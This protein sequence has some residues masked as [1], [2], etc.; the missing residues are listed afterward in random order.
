MLVGFGWAKAV[1]VDPARFRVKNQAFGMFLVAIAGASANLCIALMVLM[2][3]FATATVVSVMTGA[4]PFDVFWFLVPRDPQADLQG[5]VAAFTSYM[6]TANLLLGLFNLLPLPPLDGFQALMSLYFLMRGSLKPGAPQPT[7][8]HPV[9]PTAEAQESTAAPAK[10]HLQ[11]ALQYHKD[12]QID[13]AIARYRQ[14]L[15]HD[16]GLALAYYN[17]G[18]AYW[19]KGRFPLAASAFKAA[20]RPGADPT[21]RSLAALRLRELAQAEREPTAPLGHVPPPLEPGGFAEVAAESV[22][23]LDPGM[24]RRQWLRLATGGIAFLLLAAT[25]WILITAAA[26]AAVG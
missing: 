23:A 5:L 18:L 14:A 8:L 13:E 19:S 7:S 6:V 1:G 4:S 24:V 21:V 15:A 22:P 9:V 10:I 2:A 26:L 17:E 3:M 16:P 25:T 20:M 12:G 11:I